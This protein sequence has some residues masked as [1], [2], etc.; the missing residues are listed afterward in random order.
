MATTTTPQT[1]NGAAT[2]WQIDAS[3]SQV[4]FGVRHL[5][6]STV[7]GYFTGLSGAIRLDENDITGSSVEVEIDAASIDTRN[8]DRD[9]H[10][11]SADFFHVEEHPTLRF[12]STGVEKKG[13]ELAVAGELTIRGETR[14]VVLR[15]EKLGQ[16]TDP[17][18][19]ERVAFRGE[20]KVNRKDFGL[21][22]NQ[23]L[24]TGGFVVGD[25]VRI[26]VEVE[27]VKAP[28]A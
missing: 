19:N 23:A 12:R 28:T 20:T 11:R 3:H 6:I 25:E 4:E 5:M 27:A 8:A 9:A 7:R 21:T 1:S 22:W 2:L 15:T 26:I 10:L 14:P 24:E 17:W 18:G 13:D 16:T